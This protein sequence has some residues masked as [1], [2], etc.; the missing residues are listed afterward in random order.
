VAVVIEALIA[1][2][3]MGMTVGLGAERHAV[4]TRPGA[5]PYVT[6]APGPTPTRAPA[7]D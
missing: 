5:A 3:V 2:A 1:A 4:V 6:P 7:P